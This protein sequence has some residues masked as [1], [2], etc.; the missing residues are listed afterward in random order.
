MS[1]AYESWIGREET[2]TQRIDVSA[3]QAMAAT[4]DI[5]HIPVQ[6]EALPPG[7]QW[8]FFNPV[9]ARRGLGVDGHPKRGGFLPPIDLPRRMWAGSRIHY[10]A[11][12]PIGVNATRRSR[13]GN[14]VNKVGRQGPLWFV[15]VEHTTSFDGARCIV[16]EQ[17]LVYRMP[18][19]ADAKA[20]APKPYEEHA[21]WGCDIV[22][23]TPLLFRYSA[24]TFNGHRIHYD[25]AYTQH[26]EG[27]PDLVVHGP[28][29]ATLL[30]QL[31]LQQGGSQ[32][33]SYFEFRAIAPLFVSSPFRLEGLRNEDG[34]LKL[35][36]R[37][38]NQELAVSASATF[39]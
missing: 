17:D 38:P 24:L 10:H 7:W 37:G 4:L 12:L 28:L 39:R 35:W 27:Y 34:T 5:E 25:Q 32:P 36:A 22:P 15:T 20:P 21:Q 29:V 1:K 26:E 9:V 31:A 16:E 23:D 18:P 14:V 30:Q 2:S 19:P 11:D 13:I 3:V 33:L 8:M 6:G